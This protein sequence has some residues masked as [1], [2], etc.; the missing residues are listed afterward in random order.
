MERKLD[1]ELDRVSVIDKR[2][3]GMPTWGV[4][5]RKSGIARGIGTTS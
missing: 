3:R 5:K 1:V 4:K 2:L